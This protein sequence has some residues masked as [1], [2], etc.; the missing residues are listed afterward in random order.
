MQ[1]VLGSLCVPLLTIETT[2]DETAAAVI[3]R[4]RDVLSSVVA[5]QDELH[6]RWRGV[7]PE[8]ASR[9]HLERIIPV[10]DEAMS[11][12]GVSKASLEAVAVAVRP[13]L[14]GS[15]LVGLSAAKG[16]AA[17]LNIPIVGYDHIAAHLYACRL[18]YGEAMIYPCVGL[19]ASGGHT[20]LFHVRSP[21]ELERLGGTIDDAAGEAFDKAASLLGLG[22]PGGPQIEKAAVGGNP[23]AYRLPRPLAKER[24]RM[25]MSFSGLKTALRYLVRPPHALSDTPPPV[26]QR[27]ADLAASFQQAAIDSILTKVELALA[28]TGCRALAIGGGVAAN[29]L[30]RESIE[31][32]G[33]KHGVK[34][35]VPPRSLCTDN[36][37]MGAIA[38]ER[39]ERG[40]NDGLELDVFPGTDRS[41]AHRK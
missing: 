28:R 37:A 26:G 21:L 10:I 6:A 8:V 16:I 3:T 23:K 7:V 24:D 38:W 29:T 1:P 12:A 39:L 27:L 33:Q 18:A 40:Q 31:R 15:L 20:S 30:L 5:S 35:F 36:A 19:V 22:Y 32:L 9:A 41:A 2:C 17:A 14:V 25:D 13:G 11:K 34:V 4:S